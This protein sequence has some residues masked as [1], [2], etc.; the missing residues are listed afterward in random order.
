MMCA[1]LRADLSASAACLERERRLPDV[2]RR[3]S[4]NATDDTPETLE[5]RMR[6]YAEKTA[7]L[8]DYYDKR[9]LLR[10]VDATRRPEMVFRT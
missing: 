2:R 7:P 6:E 5:L 8:I 3:H 9:G 1:A 4:C 10:R